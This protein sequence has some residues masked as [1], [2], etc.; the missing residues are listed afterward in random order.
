VIRDGDRI[1]FEI[2][3]Y[4]TAMPLAI[5]PLLFVATTF[6]DSAGDVAFAAGR[7]M[8]SLLYEVEPSDPAD[9]AVTAVL[10]FLVALLA[11]YI[12]ARRAARIHPMQA[13]RF[14]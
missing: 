12:P 11:C 8:E 5:D 9:F 1:G 14:E 7:V 2:D 10:L 3:P 4:E 13:L 6:G